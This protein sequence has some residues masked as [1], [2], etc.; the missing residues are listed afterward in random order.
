MTD[1]PLRPTQPDDVDVL[2]RDW[3]QSQMPKPWPASPLSRGLRPTVLP[4]RR[5]EPRYY[6]PMRS[7]LALAASVAV[8][9]LGGWLIAGRVST[10]PDAGPDLGPTKPEATELW[11]REWKQHRNRGTEV[12]PDKIKTS[13][14]LEQNPSGETTIKVDVTLEDAPPMK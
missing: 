14:S 3:F 12:R 11:R 9:A 10:P 5:P 6:R 4:F 8:L 1:M 13:L 7:R 2:L